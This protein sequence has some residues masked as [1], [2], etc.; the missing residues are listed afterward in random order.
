MVRCYIF[1]TQWSSV[2]LPMCSNGPRHV[3][4]E[5]D[6][7]EYIN[8]ITPFPTDWKT[9]VTNIF[10]KLFK[11]SDCQFALLSNYWLTSQTNFSV[12][13]TTHT[14]RPWHLDMYGNKSV[15]LLNVNHDGKMIVKWVLNSCL[16]S[17]NFPWNNKYNKGW[18][19]PANDR[20]RYKVLIIHQ[21]RIK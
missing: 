7:T 21:S 11:S 10:H 2:K 6:S 16:C 14:L 15:F 9:Y 3:T 12:A 4:H 17:I 1:L 20:R 8:T 13:T 18:L 5:Y 19:R